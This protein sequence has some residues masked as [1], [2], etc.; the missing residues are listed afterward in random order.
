[1]T[2]TDVPAAPRPPRFRK[3]NYNLLHAFPLPLTVQALPPLIPHNPLSLLHVAYVYLFQRTPSHPEKLYVGS[4]SRTTRSVNVTDDRSIKALWNYGFFGKGSLSRSEPTWLSRRR[5]AVGI[6]GPDEALTAEEITDRRRK[7]RREFKQ[8][9]ARAE[10]ERIQKQLVEEGK[11][12]RSARAADDDKSSGDNQ[13]VK[14]VHFVIEPKPDPERVLPPVIDVED[15]EHLQLTLEE[16]FFLSYGLGVLEITDPENNGRLNMQE[17]LELSRRHSYFPPLTTEVQ[18]DDPF[19]INYV[20]YHHFRSL[21]WVVKP[22]VKF[23]VDYLLYNR[24]PVFSHAEFGVLILP[25]YSDPYWNNDEKRKQ[26]EQKPW[27][28]LHCINRVSAQVK[29]TVILVYV[30]IPPPSKAENSNIGDMLKAYG[31]REV[32]IRR[33]LVSK[34]RD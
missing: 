13:S 25:A 14:S 7:E 21:G 33:F 6:L 9:R 2:S 22:G 23:G 24:G 30:E 17:L 28:W 31:V 1:M 32:S 26:A 16:A 27:H 10:A 4:L 11:L 20:V 15:L 12:V 19:M 29:K 3:P 34:N 8:E 18:V 5:R